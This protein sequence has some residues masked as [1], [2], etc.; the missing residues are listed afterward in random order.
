MQAN[1]EIARKQP[2]NDNSRFSRSINFEIDVA[3]ISRSG[4]LMVSWFAWNIKEVRR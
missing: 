1:S 4:D 2:R 3:N